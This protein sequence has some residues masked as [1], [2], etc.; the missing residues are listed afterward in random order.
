[1]LHCYDLVDWIA[2]FSVI[3][4]HHKRDWIFLPFFPESGADLQALL[5]DAQLAAVHDLLNSKEAHEPGNMPLIT[6][7]LLRSICDN[8]RPSVSEA[9]KQRLYSIYSQ[10]LDAKR[11][12]A[13]QVFLIHPLTF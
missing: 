13:A 11:S 6:S 4:H 5:S 3:F 1:M 10:F 9:E 2:Y 7:T 8:A 12:A